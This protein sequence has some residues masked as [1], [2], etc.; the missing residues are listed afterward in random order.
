MRR[1]GFYCVLSL[2]T[3]SALALVG[4]A[5]NSPVPASQTANGMSGSV[6]GGQQ[7]IV[8]GSIQLYAVGSSGDGSAATPLLSTPVVSDSAGLFT[9]SGLYTCPSSSALVYITATGGNPSPGITNPQIA[10]MA[11]LG[12]CGSLNNS[13]FININE[14]TTVAAVYGLASFMSSASAVGSSPAH[15]AALTSA[16]LYAGYFAD[17]STGNTP[18][19][20]V[21]AND[22]VPVTQ[23][24]TIADILG[25]C[26][27]SAGGVSGDG[28]LCGNFF[29]LTLPQGHVAPTDS[30]AA[31]LN[32]AN[33]PTLNTAAL[34]NLMPPAPP[35][36]PTQTIVPPDF[37]LHLLASS[38]FMVT[39]STLSFSS[40][41]VNFSQPTQIITVTNGT[42]SAVNITSATISGVNASDFAVVPQ[43]GSD[44]TFTVPANSTCTFQISFK[45]SATGS[46]AAYFIVG[47]TSANPSIPIALSGSGASGAAGP[48]MLSP[49]TL[50]FTLLGTPQTL[51]LTNQGSKPLAIDSIQISSTS[52]T[53]TNN[54]GS[55]LGP[56][57][58][59]SINVMVPSYTSSTPA[60][61]TVFDDASSGPQTATVS[62][63][64]SGIVTFPPTVDFGHW[65]VGATGSEFLQ[66]IGPGIGGGYSFT[67]SGTNAT[68]FSFS[69]SSS[70]LSSSCS[71]DYRN[72]TYCYISLFFKPSVVGVS[73]AYL[74][75]PGVGRFALT[76]TGDSSA[77][78]FDLYQPLPQGTS[79]TLYGAPISALNFG[80][81]TLT[82]PVTLPFAIKN[83]GT[84]TPLA[85]NAP[86]ISGPNAADFAVTAPT[87]SGGCSLTVTFTP[88]GFGTR[89]ATLTYTD[90]TS[91]VT[92]TLALTGVGTT[93]PPVLTATTDLNFSNTPLNT[94]SSPQTI[95]VNAHQN[96]PIQASITSTFVGGPQPFIFTGPSFCATT[97]CT[98]SI[99]YAPTAS[100]G[101]A[102]ANVYVIAT[103]T[104]GSSSGN[105]QAYGQ[106]APLADVSYNPTSLSFSPQALHT[107]SSP[108]TVTFTNT[109]TTVLMLTFSVSPFG[110]DYT[111]AN[112]CPASLAINA[113]CTVDVR[114]APVSTTGTL[115]A[116]LI[117]NG[118]NVTNYIDLSGTAF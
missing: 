89:S 91:A 108:Q 96:H 48:A 35:Y 23:I 76:G 63:S 60:T 30:I 8:G 22:S 65:S 19:T 6:Y 82:V 114:F 75:V 18:G 109:G 38:L 107:V 101:S 59:C 58:S 116:N 79:S 67:I 62:F 17:T 80:S 13:T 73:N 105:I 112:H 37:S 10:L 26:I 87:C 29:S 95:T 27:N 14:I 46:R 64:G 94:V 15:A 44:C 50:A 47:N 31:L 21:P 5:T 16:F 43:P 71:Y 111:L 98:L 93:P 3:L 28:S 118:A 104:V 56:A 12:P 42:P 36:Q 2:T 54:C 69:Q 7:P 51:T 52:Y 117:I 103:D 20:N 92:R 45:P 99:A 32:L 100:T 97:P 24:D 86:V 83:T 106:V 113:A 4:C 49:S 55:S 85:L 78:D 33:N 9:I 68:D 115:S 1:F 34:Y 88:S 40:A 77:I 102:G 11:A 66:M 25:A 70:V 57:S 39:P 110:G 74:N 90:T 84:V 53:Q 41:V 61:L 72:K 81:S